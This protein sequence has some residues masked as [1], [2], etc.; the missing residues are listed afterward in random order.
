MKAFK[1]ILSILSIFI[2][3]ISICFNFIILSSSTNSLL[4]KDSVDARTKLYFSAST[5]IENIGNFT[6][7]IYNHNTNQE[8][9]IHCKYIY[10][11][12]AETSTHDCAMLSYQYD[13]N[14]NLIRTSYFPG[15]GFQY[16]KEGESIGKFEY[17]NKALLS[18]A[19]TAPARMYCHTLYYLALDPNDYIDVEKNISM[20]YDTSFNFV[21][22]KFS[23]YKSISFN[24]DVNGS[25]TIGEFDFDNKDRVVRT[26]VSSPSAPSLYNTISIDYNYTEPVVPSFVKGL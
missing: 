1:I 8:D 12:K 25:K 18:Y 14:S 13:S 7:K 19:L 9:N 15:D 24:Y 16:Y 10:D 22:S 21:F 4:F 5:K 17:S 3:I 26:Y 23:F 2:L 6:A 20:S 11:S